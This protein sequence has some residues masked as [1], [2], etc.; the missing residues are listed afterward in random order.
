MPTPR[1]RARR[2]A[3]LLPLLAGSAAGAAELVL[4][5]DAPAR[6]ACTREKEVHLI[7]HAEG[8]HNSGELA[9]EAAGLH[10][11]NASHA[12][13]QAAHGVPWV[14]HA[15]ATGTTYTDPMLT[16]KGRQ[17]CYSLRAALGDFAVDAVLVSPFRRTIAT[18]LL[19]LPQLENAAAA[20]P[21]G[22][23]THPA[24][25]TAH[26]HAAA[27]PAPP[28]VVALESLRERIGPYESDHRL[29]ISALRAHFRGLP[30]D[31][32]RVE[33][34]EDALFR[35]GLPAG[36]EVGERGQE[37]LAERGRASLAA[38][39]ALPAEQRRVALVSHKHF[40]ERLVGLYPQLPQPP[41]ANAERRAL[42][43][44]EREAARVVVGSD[45]RVR[46][47]DP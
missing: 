9:A 6:G 29:S 4:L 27:E 40:L 42:H 33:H 12:A 20:F 2:A 22:G 38:V 44:C 14:L 30:V 26:S 13:L 3:L 15:D 35:R 28:P 7:R 16:R 18:A 1:R 43:L 8:I 32:S 37:L 23:A 47:M 24:P 25:P 36:L 10:A 31:F 41:F 34:D 21:L 46:P 19:G 17:Q 5:A 45:A 11:R 39:I